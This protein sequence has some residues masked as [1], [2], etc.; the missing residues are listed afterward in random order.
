[1]VNHVQNLSSASLNNSTVSMNSSNLLNKRSVSSLS[2]SSSTPSPNALNI[3]N[4]NSLN[5]N[6]QK[7]ILG[8]RLS[9]LQNQSLRLNTATSSAVAITRRT[10]DAAAT[11]DTSIIEG[12][13]LHVSYKIVTYSQNI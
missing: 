1:M 13:T 5:R 3:T 8:K 12:F 10:T 7:K 11:T 9:K 2:L 4:T 6:N